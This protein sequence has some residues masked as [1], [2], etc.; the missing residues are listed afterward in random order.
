M[1][2]L[3]VEPPLPPIGAEE[4]LF[5]EHTA[6]RWAIPGIV[7]EG[8]TILAG[9]PKMGK[10]W[11]CLDMAT[12]I[13]SGGYA[14]GHIQVGGGNVLY[15]ALEDTHRR[16]RDRLDRLLRGG[17][18]PTG[19]AFISSEHNFPRLDRGGKLRI[20]AW[21]DQHPAARM[22]IIDT[23]AKFKSQRPLRGGTYDQDYGSVR[24]LLELAGERR[25]AVVV[26]HHTRKAIAEDSLATISG[27]FGLPGG[28]DGTLVLK[29]ERGRAD[30]VLHV[31]GRDVDEKELALTWDATA[32]RWTVAG[33]AEEF[34]RSQIRTA[35]L[36]VLR[37]EQ[38]AMS[39]K[40]VYE[41]LELADARTSYNAVKQR[42]YQMS[43]PG[44]LGV[45]EGKYS[46]GSR[47]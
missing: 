4:L 31:T 23:L 29:R 37:N 33:E 38:R 28:V 44:L 16:L 45:S 26:V 47:R 10:S 1:R 34:R 35:I 18:I 20:E 24:E 9:A 13:A 30:A 32:T 7:P 43:K 8:L 42:M 25:I 46:V 41:E 21:L 19:L 27:S 22:V 39:P 3:L 5:K 11:L 14:L 6:L 2:D 17:A 12:A 36:N 40:E 15:L